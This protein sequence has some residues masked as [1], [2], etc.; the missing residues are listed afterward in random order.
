[1]KTIF[2]P[3]DFSKYAHSALKMAGE[4]AAKTGASVTVHHNV[5]T[6]T[7]WDALSRAERANHPE[8]LQATEEAKTKIDRLVENLIG[9]GVAVHPL[10]THGIT[11]DEIVEKA[12]VTEASLILMGSHGVEDDRRFIGSTIQKVIRNSD[13]PVLNVKT[14]GHASEIT[15]ILFPFSFSEDVERPFRDVLALAREFEATIELLYINT[16]AKFTSSEAI[17]DKMK[18]FARMYPYQNFTIAT[19]DHTDPVQ[20][21]LEYIQKNPPSLVAMLSH[22]R[23]HKAGY[24]IGMTETVVFHASVPVLSLNE[25]AYKNA[26]V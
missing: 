25:R 13:C 22:D 4:I 3:T 16:P 24:L 19:F 1:M 20:G 10:I 17:E 12:R 26:L 15:K 6:L 9:P 14:G 21:I 23:K 8:V 2:V 18:S 7:N 5:P 11:A